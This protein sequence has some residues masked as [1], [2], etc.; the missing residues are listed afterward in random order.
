MPYEVVNFKKISRKELGL[1]DDKKYLIGV[2]RLVKRKGFE[3]LIKSLKLLNE[4]VECLIIGDGPEKENLQQLA[5]NLGLKQRVNLL[6][7]LSEEEK[8]FQY[9]AAAD[10]FVLSS[11][12]E[13][14]G[15]VLQEAMQVGLPI[16]AT[17]NGGQVDLIR[18]GK[19]GFLIK[20]G[21]KYMLIHEIKKI[22]ND[23]KLKESI[24]YNNLLKIKEFETDIICNKYINSFY[25]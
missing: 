24:K 2:G 8:K 3:Y 14:F 17:D 19:N 10:I 4:D 13:G 22:F 7:Y 16:I 5:V 20:F 1:K 6:G 9:L 15:I 12:H 21:N 18:N 11:L 25:Y 23:Q